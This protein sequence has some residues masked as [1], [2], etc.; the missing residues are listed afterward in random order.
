MSASKVLIACP[1]FNN[2]GRRTF[3][4]SVLFTALF[5]L[6]AH[7]DPALDIASGKALFEKSWVSAPSSTQASDGLGPYYDARSCAA[8]H[9]A[10]GQGAF[11]ASLVLI[12][13]DAIYG[14]QL[15]QHAVQGLPAEGQFSVT[16]GI[17]ADSLPTV[18]FALQNLQFGELKH[19]GFLRLPPSLQGIAAFERVTDA[20]LQQLADAND[21]NHDGISGRIAGRYGVKGTTSSL[22]QQIA[23]AFSID[24]GLSA[25]AALSPHGDCTEAQA[26]CLQ[27]PAGAG[28]GEPEVPLQVSPLIESY[29]SALPLPQ[30]R[31]DP[32]GEQVFAALGCS[33]CHVT[34]LAIPDAELHAWTDLLLHDLGPGLAAELPAPANPAQ[35]APAEWRTA[36]L[37]GLAGRSRYLHDGRA[38]SLDAAIRWHGGEAEPSRNAYNEATKLQRDRLLAFLRGL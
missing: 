23:K 18:D 12:T 10:G 35:P 14:K 3:S 34:A 22:A 5:A 11:P 27:Y 8:C 26:A 17:N 21:A 38:D 19:R 1:L 7:G 2:A 15:Q 24:M 37:W 9:P 20:T 6:G 29:L 16:T 30:S 13:D 28:A 31:V 4:A 32:A 36:P 25:V 33:A